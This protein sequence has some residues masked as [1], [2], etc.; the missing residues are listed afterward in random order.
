MEYVR[1][2]TALLT[3][4]KQERTPPKAWKVL[5]LMW[6]YAGTHETGGRIP[7]EACRVVGL[8]SSVAAQLEEIGWMHR[9]GSGWVLNDWEDHQVD[10]DEMRER[11]EARRAQWR[12]SKQRRREEE[13]RA[14]S[15]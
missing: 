9:N 1:L 13:R 6:L 10:V 14:E 15:T 11:R 3:H 7:P 8:T 12:Q 2:Y 4:P 5:T